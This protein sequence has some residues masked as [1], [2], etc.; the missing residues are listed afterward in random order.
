MILLRIFILNLN[1]LPF[2]TSLKRKSNLYFI[3]GVISYVLGLI[4]TGFVLTKFNH[5]QP[6]LLYLVPSCVLTPLSVA[7]VKGDLK[8]MF[9]YQDHPTEETET[10]AEDKKNE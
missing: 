3:V 10:K 1:F 4:T 6:A 9:A 8:T 7:L 5:A 2:S